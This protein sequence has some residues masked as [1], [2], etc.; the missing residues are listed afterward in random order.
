MQG[1]QELSRLSPTPQGLGASPHPCLQLTLHT[2]GVQS[3]CLGYTL[4]PLKPR[5]HRAGRSRHNDE[6]PHVPAVS[7]KMGT[8]FPTVFCLD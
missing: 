5:M 3:V 8:I 2:V 4:P 7:E 1:G 6:G